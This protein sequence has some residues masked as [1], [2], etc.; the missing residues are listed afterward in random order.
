MQKLNNESKIHT[1]SN[2]NLMSLLSKDFI[3][4]KTFTDIYGGEGVEYIKTFIKDNNNILISLRENDA[5]KF[6]SQK[7]GDIDIAKTLYNF[8]IENKLKDNAIENL[9]EEVHEINDELNVYKKHANEN[10]KKLSNAIKELHNKHIVATQG[11]SK[12][13]MIKR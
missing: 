9:K 7:L 2:D 8:Y 4:T 13:R 1:S 12:L 6:I 11:K 5:I 10:D 3:D